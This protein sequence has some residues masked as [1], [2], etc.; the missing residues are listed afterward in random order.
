MTRREEMLRV[1]GSYGPEPVQSIA[2]RHFL[3]PNPS[4]LLP[5]GLEQA[6]H[7]KAAKKKDLA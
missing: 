4:K 1:E 2:N 7:C 6:I 5:K 3:A